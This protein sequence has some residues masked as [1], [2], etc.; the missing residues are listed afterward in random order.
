[1]GVGRYFTKTLIFGYFLLLSCIAAAQVVSEPSYA[2]GLDAD[3][4][5]YHS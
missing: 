3:C 4:H 5:L 1:M 2:V